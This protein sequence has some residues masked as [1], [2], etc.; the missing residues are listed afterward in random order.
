MLLPNIYEWVVDVFRTAS[1][2]RKDAQPVS[3]NLLIT[4]VK[5]NNIKFY[6]APIDFVEEISILSTIVGQRICMSAQVRPLVRKRP[7]EA[8]TSKDSRGYC[9]N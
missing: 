9:F 1:A 6:C 5:I 7:L 4:I 2:I 3:H 8:L